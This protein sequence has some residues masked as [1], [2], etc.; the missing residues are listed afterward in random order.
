MSNRN[1][2]NVLV[3]TG[4]GVNCENETARAFKLCGVNTQIMHVNELEGKNDVLKTFHI[5]ALPGGFSFGDELGSGKVFS[6]K[7]QKYLG[8]EIRHFVKTGHPVI[9]ICNGFQV[10]TKLSLF[11]EKP[12]TVGLAPNNHGNFMNKWATLNVEP[13]KS[14]WLKGIKNL[15]LPIRHGEGR[16]VFNDLGGVDLESFK[17]KGMVALTYQDN[18]NCSTGDIAGVCDE[19]GL[20]FGLMPHPEAAVKEELY[21]GGEIVGDP[22]LKIFENAVNYVEENLF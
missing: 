19:S 8:E 4:D 6:L 10:L 17:R 2:I 21:P 18:P 3:L 5:L 15:R 11:T 20:V 16:F 9:G 22:G 13:N 1:K 7:L 14:I 12:N